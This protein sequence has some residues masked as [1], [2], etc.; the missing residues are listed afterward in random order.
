MA[1]GQRQRRQPAVERFG[2]VLMSML[3]SAQPN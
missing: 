3:S 2:G 1:D